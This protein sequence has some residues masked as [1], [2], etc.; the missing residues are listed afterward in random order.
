MNDINKKEIEKKN[1]DPQLMEDYNTN[2]EAP[3]RKGG[4]FDPLAKIL[5][6]ITMAVFG[7]GTIIGDR[8]GR[9]TAAEI[10]VP[11]NFVKSKS[12]FEIYQQKEPQKGEY[13][14][15]FIGRKGDGN[16][17]NTN[18]VEIAANSKSDEVGNG[19]G[20]AG[21]KLY[22]DGKAYSLATIQISEASN[23]GR[24]PGAIV[25]LQGEGKGGGVQ[26]AYFD[27]NGVNQSYILL[28]KDGLQTFPNISAKSGHVNYDGSAGTVFPAGWTSTNLS[29]GTYR[30]THNMNK[31]DYVVLA[32][33]FNVFPFAVA[34]SNNYFD[35]NMMTVGGTPTNCA[36]NFAV[37]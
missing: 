37:Y 31:S 23:Q 30:V 18:Y 11:A 28:D 32:T 4:A 24:D 6:N 1:V 9:L 12:V 16:Y 15:M 29:P 3:R 26:L 2:A 22:R 14:L 21:F 13:N 10:S 20:Q 8:P 33:M 25:M 5:R 19:N 35:V 27:E 36:F 7:T 17:L 34:Q